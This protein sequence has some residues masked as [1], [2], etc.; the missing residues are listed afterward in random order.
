MAMRS[1]KFTAPEKEVEKTKT[2]QLD[3]TAVNKRVAS[4]FQDRTRS[5][6]CPQEL[7]IVVAT[8]YGGGDNGPGHKEC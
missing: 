8:V 3:Q 1:T 5:L 7:P 6:P 4:G 2:V